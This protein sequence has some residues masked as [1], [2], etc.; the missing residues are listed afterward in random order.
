MIFTLAPQKI[1]ME[2]FV[3]PAWIAGVHQIRRMRRETSMSTWVPSLHAGTTQSR[4][5]TKTTQEPPSYSRRSMRR[6]QSWKSEFRNSN[7]QILLCVLGA[8]AV[9][10]LSYL[11]LRQPRLNVTP[12]AAKIQDD[13]VGIGERILSDAA[14]VHIFFRDV[15][16]NSAGDVFRRGLGE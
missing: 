1:K 8:C 16:E 14:A 3:M 2:I 5:R 7:F 11:G 12:L 4:S 10:V 6:T 9:I 15:S 13:A